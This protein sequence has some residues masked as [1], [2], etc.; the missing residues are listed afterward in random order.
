MYV[1]RTFVYSP[2]SLWAMVAVLALGTRT[3]ASPKDGKR[4]PGTKY[5]SQARLFCICGGDDPSYTSSSFVDY[6][7]DDFFIFR[8]SHIP[9]W[10]QRKTSQKKVFVFSSLMGHA[11]WYDHAPFQNEFYTKW[12]L[13]LALLKR[14]FSSDCYHMHDMGRC[15]TCPICWCAKKC[16]WRSF[17]SILKESADVWLN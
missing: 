10:V 2:G 12:I 4:D 16:P 7:W 13:C 15:M 1:N 11:G 6:V 14:L 8:S 3:H 17:A 9:I 5:E